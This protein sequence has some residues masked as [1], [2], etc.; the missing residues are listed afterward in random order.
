M[1]GFSGVKSFQTEGFSI[2][3]IINRVFPLPE[4]SGKHLEL[5]S[6]TIFQLH[7]IHKIF[8]HCEFSDVFW[9]LI[10]GQNFSHICYTEKVSPLYE[11]SDDH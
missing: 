7:Y 4:F 5:T 2:V 1:C 3:I 6:Y 11:L 10:S 8:P 9:G